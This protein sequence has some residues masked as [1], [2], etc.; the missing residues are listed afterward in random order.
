MQREP[1]LKNGR[2]KRKIQKKTKTRL[3]KRATRIRWEFQI[4][5]CRDSHL[6]QVG[7]RRKAGLALGVGWGREWKVNETHSRGVQLNGI[8]ADDCSD[9]EFT[10]SLL[11]DPSGRRQHTMTKFNVRQTT[12]WWI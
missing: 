11:T 5:A 10:G 12:G 7:R 6:E 3:R 1:K 4:W 9:A 2:K 8:N